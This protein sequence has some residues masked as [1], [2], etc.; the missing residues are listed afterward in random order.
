MLLDDALEQGGGFLAPPGSCQQNGRL[1][2]AKTP[3]V[4]HRLDE[5]NGAMNE[6]NQSLLVS[7]PSK[8]VQ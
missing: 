8:H 6:R 1:L 7:L 2:Q 4:T 5:W 3:A